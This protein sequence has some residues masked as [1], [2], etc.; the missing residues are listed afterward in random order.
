MYHVKEHLNGV[1]LN[2]THSAPQLPLPAD[3]P[4]WPSYQM[5]C[6]HVAASN[7]ATHVCITVDGDGTRSW[8]LAPGNGV[9]LAAAIESWLQKN[10]TLTDLTVVIPLDRRIYMATIDG[11][12]V[13]EEIALVEARA[14][15]ALQNISATHPIMLFNADGKANGVAAQI[16]SAEPLPMDL[17]T[18]RYEWA[19]WVF[20]KHRMLHKAHLL[21]FMFGIFIW[22]SVWFLQPTEDLVQ[23]TIRLIQAP[24]AIEQVSVSA[25]AHIQALAEALRPDLISALVPQH[26]STLSLQDGMLRVQGKVVGHYPQAAMDQAHQHKGTFQI[27]SNGWSAQWPMQLPASTRPLTDYQH[28]VV[29]NAVYKAAH[30][31]QGVVTMQA[32]FNETMAAGATLKITINR[33]TPLRLRRLAA[34]LAG[35]AVTLDVA[36]C[37]F[38]RYL[39]TECQFTLSTRGQTL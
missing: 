33:P 38:S 20:L 30:Q 31:A 18:Y 34:G 4:Y 28:L 12:L 32:S 5:I 23:E 10:P 39:N 14:L 24:A 22:L 8:R 37:H 26:L 13:T 16:A 15:E 29:L 11:G 9:S 19:P 17:R 1:R 25:A 2:F 7:S 6:R 27:N 36:Q 35:Q 3:V 21:P